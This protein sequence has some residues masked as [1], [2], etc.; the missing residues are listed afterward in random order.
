MVLS[1]LVIL[2]A[3]VHHYPNPL[4]QE[5]FQNCDTLITS[6]FLHLLHGTPHF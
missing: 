2:S 5:G 4:I 3:I 1:P 6:F